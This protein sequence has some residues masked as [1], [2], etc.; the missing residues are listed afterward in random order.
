MELCLCARQ[1]AK[2]VFYWVFTK[3]VGG[4]YYYH[5]L[6]QGSH[7]YIEYTGPLTSQTIPLTHF[8]QVYSKFYGLDSLIVISTCSLKCFLGWEVAR[9]HNQIL[10]EMRAASEN[11][12]ATVGTGKW[13][14]AGCPPICMLKPWPQKLGVWLYLMI[15]LSEG[16]IK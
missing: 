9:Y 15:G 1:L 13:L 8:N 16:R 7:G 5:Y 12:E 11:C 14:R 10:Y 2:A 6:F 4:T 3:T